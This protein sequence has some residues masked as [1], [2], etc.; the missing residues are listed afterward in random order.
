MTYTGGTGDDNV[1]GSNNNANMFNVGNGN[2][3]VMA[4][5]TGANTVTS[6]AGSDHI[7]VG[8]GSN[9]IITGDGADFVTTGSGTNT[10]TMGTGAETLALG[11]GS[12]T[13]SLGVHGAGVSDKVSVAAT[14]NGSFVPTAIIT[15]LNTVGLDTIT[16][17]SDTA[18]GFTSYTAGQL[19]TFGNALGNN[20]TAGSAPPTLAAAVAD[21]LG[22][23]GG[24]LALHGIGAF[25]YGGN[26]YLL[27][28]GLTGSPPVTAD[29]FGAGDTLVELIGAPTINTTTVSAG[30]LH[31][32]T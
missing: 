12:N 32:L 17:T 11:S 3:I 23:A 8:N 5:G 25:Q 16:F 13:V 2:N 10:I 21:V 26:T 31:L 24:N 4:S 7:T 6:G 15:G 30:V 1:T 29:T 20:V 19:I 28:H 9:T 14:T 27:E 18:T 22:A